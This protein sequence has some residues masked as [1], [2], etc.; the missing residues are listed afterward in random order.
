MSFSLIIIKGGRIKWV[1][2]TLYDAVIAD[3]F[4][5]REFGTG[6]LKVT[7]AHDLNDYELGKKHGLPLISV[8]NRDAS[9]NSLGGARYAGLT[10]EQCRDRIWEDIQ[11]AGLALTEINSSGTGTQPHLQRVPRSQRGGE[12]IE[13][14]VS[15]QWFVRADGMAENAVKAVRQGDIAIL[16]ERYEKVWYNWLE[17]IHDWCISRQ[18]WWGHRIPVYYVN[19]P[20]A[21]P[22]QATSSAGSAAA[23]VAKDA[24]SRPYVVARSLEEA[25][26]MA[27]EQYGAGVTVTQDEDVLDT[28]FR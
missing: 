26:R 19:A 5:D 16:P 1:L 12:V 22:A 7:P 18:L 20:A 4:V 25:Q 3:E 2:Q 14:M 13:P 6:A 23:A 17:N 9:I 21:A 24:D 27:V 8:M 11:Q 28:W 15:P 10:R